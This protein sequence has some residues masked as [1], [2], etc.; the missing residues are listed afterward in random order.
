MRRLTSEQMQ[1][2]TK[3]QV[4]KHALATQV[5]LDNAIA[6][7]QRFGQALAQMGYFPNRTPDQVQHNQGAPRA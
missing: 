2:M 7:A 3:E 1:A 5:E 4:I 6:R